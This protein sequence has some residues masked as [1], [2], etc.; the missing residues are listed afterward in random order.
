M[1]KKIKEFFI[2]LI[3]K[4]H[5]KN[6]NL[7]TPEEQDEIRK[8][9][10]KNHYIILTRR[11]NHLSTYFIGLA[12]FLLKGKWGFWSHA[13]MNLENTTEADSDFRLIEAIGAGVQYTRFE[14]VF[15]VNAVV[16]LKPKSMTIEEWT[17]V[18]VKANTEIGKPYDSL[19]DLANDNALNCVE[20]V[21]TALQAQPNY[22]SDFEHFETTIVKAKNLTPQMF[23]DCPDF[24]IV[25][26]VRH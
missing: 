20:L 15:N 16:L 7:V 17:D 22:A 5:W 13:L 14:R 24:E 19:F 4:I 10:N 6:N 1:L 11:N 21:R 26:E 25:Y 2:L 9:L 18:L 3:G 12:D 8:F 23:Y